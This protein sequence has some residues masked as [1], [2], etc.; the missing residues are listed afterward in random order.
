MG[1]EKR[2]SVGYRM[3]AK[4]PA[5]HFLSPGQYEGMKMQLHGLTVEANRDHCCGLEV[6]G[7]PQTA[8]SEH[9][10]PK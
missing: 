1:Q 8:V 5:L 6:K 3:L 9:S 4:V 2:S 7:P 10:E